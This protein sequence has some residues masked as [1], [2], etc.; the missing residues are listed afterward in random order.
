MIIEILRHTIMITA[1]VLVMMLIIEYINV[2]TR[3]S[4]I[5]P[6]QKKGWLQIIL[7]AVLGVI[8]GC[9]GT[10][11]AVSLY[12]HKIFSFAAL[13]TVMI[14][15]AGDEAFIMLSVIPNSALILFAIITGVAIVTGFI[16]YAFMGNKTL[17]KLPENHLR[18]HE[19][20]TNCICFDPKGIVKQFKR[21]SFQRA[22]LIVGILLF[23]FG[24]VTGQFTHSHNIIPTEQIEMNHDHAQH[25]HSI[26]D[27]SH[28]HSPA[29]SDAHAGHEHHG[30]WNW[31]S[32]TFLVVSLI[33]LFIISTV[34]DHF[35]EEHLWGHII[36]KHFLKIFLWTLGALI[37]IQ[38]LTNH[39]DISH[40][41]E[42]N[43]LTILLIAV[44]IGIIPESG[45]HYIFV[46]LF[47]QGSIPISILIANSIVQDGHGALPLLAESKKSFIIVKLINLLVGLLI[48]YMGLQLGF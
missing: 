28:D 1:F 19:G 7:A 12:S 16:L 38:L 43:M 27:D 2:Q 34:N 40:W 32:T 9:L 23:L 24:L 44:L 8:P 10:Y 15:T 21:I 30:D 36:K 47:A 25:D 11:T 6:L 39:L 41:M 46:L 35:L 33:A 4:W 5:S 42:Q 14:A 29:T 45:P 18:L 3:G 20:E 13:V 48:G 26:A 37:V 17:M 31:I 22:I